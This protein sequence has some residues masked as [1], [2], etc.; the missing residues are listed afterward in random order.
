MSG[1]KSRNKGARRE[2]EVAKEM[3][4]RKVSGMYRKGPDL[5]LMD[6]GELIEVKARAEGWKILRRW[7]APVTYLVLVADRAEPMVV[8]S[9]SEWKRLRGGGSDGE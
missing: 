3:G 5:K 2:R 9:M 7:L 8:M 1:S 4:A 6:T